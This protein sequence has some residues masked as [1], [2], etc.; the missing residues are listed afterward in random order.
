M[1]SERLLV[2]SETED[3]SQAEAEIRSFEEY[4]L[5]FFPEEVER[6]RQAK[7][8]P[9]QRAREAGRKAAEQMLGRVRKALPQWDAS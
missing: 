7:L 6:E 1:K 9:E 2:R 3:Q 4:R 5:R 8:T